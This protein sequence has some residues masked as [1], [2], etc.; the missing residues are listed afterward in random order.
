MSDRGAH[1]E[2]RRRCVR[3][4]PR[5]RGRHRRAPEAQREVFLLREMAGI[6]FHESPRMTGAPDHGEEPHAVRARGPP[7]AAD[8]GRHR[9]GCRRTG[10]MRPPVPP[11][12]A[13]PMTTG[14]SSWPTA[15]RRPPRRVRSASTSTDV[16]LPD[17]P[18]GI[19]EVR[20]AF[21]SVPTEPAPE[22]GLESLLAYGEQAAARARS[23]R[24]GLRILALLSAA[25]ASRWCGSCCPHPSGSRT[26]SPGRRPPG[27]RTRW[28]S[29]GP[30]GGGAGRPR[31][32]RA[33]RPG[34]GQEGKSE[35]EKSAAGA[36]GQVGAIP[37]RSRPCPSAGPRRSL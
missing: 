22:R 5:A 21:R 2:G 16:P 11:C 36:A 4:A 30:A 37:A 10:G 33:R 6:P 9:R 12:P 14:S 24:G 13:I 31:A 26:A 32:G 1:T 29:G 18:G 20:S 8:R 15:R 28:H 7:H 3:A 27:P 34:E 25:T 35:S 19:A 23:R 17:R